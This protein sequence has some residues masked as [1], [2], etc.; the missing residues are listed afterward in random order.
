M[1]IINTMKVII[2]N[3]D[4]LLYKNI[5][6]SKIVN[7]AIKVVMKLYKNIE[8]DLSYNKYAYFHITLV[9]L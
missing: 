4:L 6:K 8:V 7:E 2:I 1:K 5:H 9:Y 3:L